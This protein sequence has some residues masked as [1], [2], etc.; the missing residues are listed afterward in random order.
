MLGVMV[1]E[2]ELVDDEAVL[3]ERRA[4]VEQEEEVERRLLPP[5]RPEQS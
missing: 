3:D 5:V 4:E 2:D 1:R